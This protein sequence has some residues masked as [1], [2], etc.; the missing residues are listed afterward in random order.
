MNPIRLAGALMGVAALVAVS[1]CSGETPTPT[2]SVTVGDVSLTVATM[3]APDHPQ[4]VAL[5]ELGTRLA[6][7]TDG[8][9]TLDVQTDGA[10]GTE[11]TALQGV[12]EGTVGLAIVGGRSLE[13]FNED[14]LALNSAYVFASPEAQAA[15]LTDE[16]VTSTLLTSLEESR[17]VSVLGGLYGGTRNL[18]NADHPVLTP[19]DLDGL[20]VR[21]EASQVD[22]TLVESLGAVAAPLALNEV[23]AALENGVV[24]AAE[25]TVDAYTSLGHDAVAPYY[26]YT[27]HLMIPDYLVMNTDTLN[28]LSGADRQ[29]LMSAVAE[30][31]NTSNGAM[32]SWED[33][34]RASAEEA[35]ATFNEVDDIAS[36][37]ALVPDAAS[38]AAQPA[39]AEAVRAA[40]EAHP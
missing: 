14:F 23:T 6:E 21:V 17:K 33:D 4:A 40:N 38:L 5:A 8:R 26:S 10:L 15:T 3:Q 13:P 11:E 7:A 24:N 39:L 34:A 9:V 36:F 28:S 25:N 35:G 12:S 29:A 30:M 19:A 37:A 2:P 27:R 31:I 32:A 16:R 22:V 20:T 18:Y 1:A